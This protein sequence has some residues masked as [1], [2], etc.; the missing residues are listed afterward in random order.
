MPL[1]LLI[2]VV[3]ALWLSSWIFGLD[4]TGD[5]GNAYVI[6]SVTAI[7]T[8]MLVFRLFRAS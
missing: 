1:W 8:V 7:A 3:I 6:W 2:P 4:S 5:P